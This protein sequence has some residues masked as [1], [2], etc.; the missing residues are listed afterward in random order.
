[1]TNYYQGSDD[2]LTEKVILRSVKIDKFSSD[3]MSQTSDDSTEVK[4][5]VSKS[6]KSVQLGE[7]S[8]TPKNSSSSIRFNAKASKLF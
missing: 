2:D 6:F 8:S 3:N 1:M 4:R 5:D 7:K